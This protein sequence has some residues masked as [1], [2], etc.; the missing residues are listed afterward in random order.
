MSLIC[1]TDNHVTTTRPRQLTTTPRFPDALID[2]CSSTCVVFV[3]MDREPCCTGTE[4]HESLRL[5]L[6]QVGQDVRATVDDDAA[7]MQARERALEFC[8]EQLLVHLE[9]DETW[10]VRANGYSETRL[11]AQ[12]M[13]SEMRAVAGC[14]SEIADAST[15]WEAVAAIRATHALLAAHASHE[16]LLVPV[17]ARQADDDAAQ[18]QD[19]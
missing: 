12:A 14:V 4:E 6:I 9:R 15:G 11:L 10:L 5:Q 2:M 13:R 8:T 1:R 19:R 3:S 16:S 7:F 17:L 18:R